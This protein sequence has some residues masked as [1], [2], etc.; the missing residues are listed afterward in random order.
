[1]RRLGSDRPRGEVL[2]Q[3]PPAGTSVT[4]GDRI[5]LVVSR[6]PEAGA[7][8]AAA[9]AS[10]QV[11]EVVGM[12]ASDAVAAIRDAGFEARVR[13]VSS[14]R[15]AGTV[16][17]Q[18][19]A[20]ELEATEGSTVVLDVAKAR[21]PVAQ[22]VRVPDV[23]GRSA[24]AA[25]GALRSAGLTVTVVSVES[26]EPKGTVIAQ[27]PDAGAEVRKGASVRLSVSSGPTRIDVP[28]VTGLDEESARLELASGGFE[29]RVT[30]EST[31]DPGQDG[32]V[33]RQ[34]PAAGTQAAEGAVVTL[35][36]GRYG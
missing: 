2:T 7:A 23:V 6:G 15:T 29:V 14:S 8:A 18:S 11:P 16:V 34:T 30:G 27:S 20:A 21:Q 5:V 35:T 19:P 33:L 3:D 36:V 1:V 12:A 26:Q 31:T 17:R 10:S 4:E 28:D 32:V 22:R 13:L 9:A 25:Q 24:A